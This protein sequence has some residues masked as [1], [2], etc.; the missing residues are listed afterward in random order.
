MVS[1]QPQSIDHNYL[2]FHIVYEDFQMAELIVKQNVFKLVQG[3]DT[4]T[5]LVP[6]FGITSSF[7]YWTS[8]RIILIWQK[9]NFVLKRWAQDIGRKPPRRESLSYDNDLDKN[10]CFAASQNVM[11]RE[12]TS[13]KK[14]QHGDLGRRVMG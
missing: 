7:I 10:C 4:P 9:I 8:E 13:D 1:K 14:L 6:Y 5:N 12:E 11:G 2:Y 3:I